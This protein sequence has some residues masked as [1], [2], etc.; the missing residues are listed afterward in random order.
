MDRDTLREQWQANNDRPAWVREN[1]EAIHD[2]TDTSDRVPEGEL[3]EV[4][5]W[6]GRYKST[7]TTQLTAD[8]GGED[9]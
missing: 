9:E 7:V 1:R 6:L 4:R 5:D 2:Y 8:D 3:H